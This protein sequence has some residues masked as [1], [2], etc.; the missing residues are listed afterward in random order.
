[1]AS[2]NDKYKRFHQALILSPEYMGIANKDRKACK[3]FVDLATKLD[4][5]SPPDPDDVEAA[6]VAATNEARMLVTQGV[7]TVELP[8]EK[9]KNGSNTNT[10]ASTS[11][12]SHQKYEIHPAA[13][14]FPMMSDEALDELAAD[15]KDHGLRDPVVMHNGKLLDG[16]NRLEACHRAGV[17]PTLTEWTGSGSVV[18]WILSVNFHRRHLSDQQRAMI[19]ARVAQELTAESKERSA[20]NLSKSGEPVRRDKFDPSRRRTVNGTGCQPAQCLT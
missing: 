15:I 18:T 6:F 1:M 9:Q 4:K 5:P 3:E 14:I 13:A 17:K 19:A 11:P 12:A 2:I 20:R 7:L 8:D 10:E 16:R